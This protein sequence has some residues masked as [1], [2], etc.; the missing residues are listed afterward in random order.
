MV[1]E[2]LKCALF[3]SW[4]ACFRNLEPHNC[5]TQGHSSS[6]I[7]KDTE[8]LCGRPLMT[9]PPMI[10]NINK[11]MLEMRHCFKAKPPSPLVCTQNCFERDE[12]FKTSLF[13]PMFL[14]ETSQSSIK[15]DEIYILKI[16]SWNFQPDKKLW[17]VIAWHIFETPNIYRCQPCLSHAVL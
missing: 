14:I 3:N 4:T 6:Q 13:P 12:T 11:G 1:W 9:W 16:L 5:Q 15:Q 8:I 17:V 10:I 7:N 2:S